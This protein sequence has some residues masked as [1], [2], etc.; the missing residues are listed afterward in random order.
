MSSSRDCQLGL[1]DRLTLMVRVGRRRVWLMLSQYL[2]VPGS[3]SS[4]SVTMIGPLPATAA[5]I[6][7]PD[8]NLEV[9]EAGGCGRSGGAAAT[10]AA[11]AGRPHPLPVAAHCP[12]PV[13]SDNLL[14][15]SLTRMGPRILLLLLLLL[16]A[17]CRR[18]SPR[19]KA[20]QL[21]GTAVHCMVPAS[22]RLPEQLRSETRRSG[23]RAAAANAR[24]AVQSAN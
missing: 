9:G 16:P 12:M 6:Q 17:P 24:A 20:L 10:A 11:S 4:F 18:L 8:D 19:A 22:N 5:C 15:P 14:R 7:K 2:G 21:L 1:T 3:M 23:W 13:S